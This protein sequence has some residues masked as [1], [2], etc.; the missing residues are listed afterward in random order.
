MMTK[1][2]EQVFIQIISLLPALLGIWLLFYF[3]RHL[4][5]KE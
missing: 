3:I 5:F 4:F 1:K 2:S